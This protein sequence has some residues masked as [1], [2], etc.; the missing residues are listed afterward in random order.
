M[1][2]WMQI[3]VISY[4][5]IKRWSK[6][7]RILFVFVLSG[8]LTISI[9]DEVLRFSYDIKQP[10]GLLE[11]YIMMFSGMHNFMLLIGGIIL[12]FCDAPFFDNATVFF[13][14]RV[15]RTQWILG[16]IL[17]ICLTMLIYLTWLFVISALWCMDNAFIANIWSDIAML[18]SRTDASNHVGIFFSV[19]V[20]TNLS[21]IL[22][23]FHTAAFIYLYG[24]FIG[25]VMLILNMK[26]GSVEGV[27]AAMLIHLSGWALSFTMQPNLYIFS[28]ML[29]AVL[30]LHSFDYGMEPTIIQSY[31]IL[32]TIILVTAAALRFV[33]KEYNFTTSYI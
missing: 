3:F 29:N 13:L 18:L 24:I 15:G 14:I 6:N 7:P 5:N 28:P 25:L 22:A 12:L 23:F 32:F 27:C 16:Q 8:L 20:F 1:N 17:Y 21:P 2:I 9:S 11:P 10:L 26:F 33:L 4:S 31:I 19:N 30:R